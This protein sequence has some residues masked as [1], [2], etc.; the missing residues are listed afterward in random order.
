MID[1]AGIESLLR[2]CDVFYRGVSFVGWML[3]VVAAIA[4]MFACG[5][6]PGVLAVALMAGAFAGVIIA[7]LGRVPGGRRAAP[8]RDPPA[9]P[10]PPGN[11]TSGPGGSFPRG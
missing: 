1:K 2:L 6:S 7:D 11:T 9:T 5:A 10:W 8:P 4:V 3:A